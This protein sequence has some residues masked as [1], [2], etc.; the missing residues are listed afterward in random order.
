MSNLLEVRV[1]IDKM[2]NGLT[3]WL[4]FPP[5][6][7]NSNSSM[8]PILLA[9]LLPERPAPAAAIQKVVRTLYT[10]QCTGPL[11]FLSLTT[12][13]CKVVFYRIVALQDFMQIS[14]HFI[15]NITTDP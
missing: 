14:N 6:V 8:L 9:I 11:K 10:R 3:P 4:L 5:I 7:L 2:G 13:V 1:N 15:A 12:A